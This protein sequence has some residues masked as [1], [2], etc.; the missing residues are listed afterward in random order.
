MC[1]DSLS[2]TDEAAR[3][4][5]WSQPR[6][7]LSSEARDSNPRIRDSSSTRNVDQIPPMYHLL[8]KARFGKNILCDNLH[9][10]WRKASAGMMGVTKFSRLPTAFTIITIVI[11]FTLW[12]SRGQLE[13]IKQSSNGIS[14]PFISRYNPAHP[15]F[16][17]SNKKANAPHLKK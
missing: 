2:E 5:N 7:P 9:S 3:Y 1:N 10:N 16:S 12:N 4:R 17:H 11:L 15:N 8:F 13:K 14:I 6:P